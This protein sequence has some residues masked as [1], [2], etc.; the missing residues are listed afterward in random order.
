MF[1]KALDIRKE[2]AAAAGPNDREARLNLAVAYDGLG[3]VLAD[4]GLFE[5][6][7]DNNRDSLSI[8][9]ALHEKDPGFPRYR[10][11][12]SIEH[13]KIGGILE[14]SGKLDLALGEYQKA[15][16]TDEALAAEDPLNA[17][18]K[19]DVAITRESIGDVLLKT[20]DAA[21]AL[22]QYRLSV[23]IGD[24]LAAGILFSRRHY[25][26]THLKIRQFRFGAI[27]HNFSFSIS[28]N[29]LRLAIAAADAR[30]VPVVVADHSD[31]TGNSTWILAELIK[32]GA[33]NFC[34]TTISDERAIEE[35]ASKS[36]VGDRVSVNVGGWAD[37]YAGRPVK[38]D[39]KLEFLCSE[40]AVIKWNP[41]GRFS[42]KEGIP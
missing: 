34:I 32:Q 28:E 1:R 7:L 39:G 6:A 26:I 2:L 13:K 20:S 15:L 31:R 30:K 18:A 38:I 5:I 21:G 14:A 37:Q 12:I 8:F 22:K 29:G 16:Q 3:D 23:A 9:Q 36:K 41:T 42:F 10:R 24:E 19:R 11:A 25:E 27:T 4:G 40:R 17:I 35:I 33:K